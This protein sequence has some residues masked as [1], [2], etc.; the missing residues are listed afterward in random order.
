MVAL[1][2]ISRKIAP[3]RAPP[4]PC[5]GVAA[6]PLAFLF[7]D[8]DSS[9]ALFER[10]GDAVACEI[11]RQHFEFLTVIAL[12][13]NGTIVKTTGDGVLATFRSWVDAVKAALAVQTCVADFNRVH[14]AGDVDR[15]IAIK[16][17]IHA[18][19]SVKLEFPNG[20]DYF[21]STVNLAARLHCASRDGDVV[22][23]DVVAGHPGVRLLLGARPTREEN[24]P[25][26]GFDRPVRFVRVLPAPTKRALIVSKEECHDKRHFPTR[27]DHHE[28]GRGHDRGARPDAVQLGPACSS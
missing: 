6:R 14:A 17:G 28:P 12:D 1:A 11:L 15:C 9:T 18:G 4:P 16:L 27:H 25:L 2:R 20:F 7:T 23:S 13:H 24:V 8:L 3:V 19:V 21:G 22:L 5:H 10:V 26:K